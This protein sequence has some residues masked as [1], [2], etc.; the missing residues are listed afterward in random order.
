MLKYRIKNLD[1]L[2]QKFDPKV[3]ERANRAGANKAAQKTR[4]FI[5]ETIRKV[6][7]VKA[8]AIKKRVTLKRASSNMPFAELRY[9]GPRIGLINFGAKEKKVTLARKPRKGQKGQPWGRFRTGVT[10]KVKKSG[11]RKLVSSRPGFIM[12]GK[13]NNQHIYYRAGDGSD[14]NNLRSAK[15]WSIPEMLKNAEREGAGSSKA[16]ERFAAQE[17]DIEF[18]RAMK[19]FMSKSQ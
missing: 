9:R 19:H 8:M 18:D 16:Y 3:V 5:S 15:T 14:R 2:K 4:T 1:K 7:N 10:V 17:Y 12:T 13:N 6:Y 11:S